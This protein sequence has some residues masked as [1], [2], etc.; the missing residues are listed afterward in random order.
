MIERCTV[1]PRA[2]APLA[3]CAVIAVHSSPALAQQN[4]V[5]VEEFENDG[6]IW[7]VRDDQEEKL[8]IQSG[9]CHLEYKK[10][11]GGTLFLAKKKVA[12]NQSADFQI[13]TTMTC[14][15][16]SA[17]H[18]L[19][20]G[21]KDGRHYYCAL[22]S[23]QGK[24]VYARC[25]GGKL[26]VIWRR[27]MA[28][29]LY[30][31]SPSNTLTVKKIGGDVVFSLNGSFVA[32]APFQAFF[33]DHVGFMLTG[34]LNVQVEN[35]AIVTASGTQLPSGWFARSEGSFASRISRHDPKDQTKLKCAVGRSGL[36]KLA[37]PV[38]GSNVVASVTVKGGPCVWD[39]S[40]GVYIR[41]DDGAMLRLERTRVDN[42]I[43]ARLSSSAGGKVHGS[44]HIVLPQED[45]LLRLSRNGDAFKGE[46]LCQ[47][48]STEVASLNWPGLTAKQE[49]G[50]ILDYTKPN[51]KFPFAAYNYELVAPRVEPGM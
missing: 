19:V 30:H 47:G 23:S 28:A 4:A 14:S 6:N 49:A 21:F 34:K 40:C 27:D 8:A 45:V 48:K 35:L 33:G 38:A 26:N 12:I 10:A 46:A 18:G 20:W 42:A 16:G 9:K 44:K 11:R 51:P 7:G 36:L 25:F 22:V 41:T 5:F 2:I 15:A 1:L 37:R 17:L 32:Q 31:P 24:F 29:G 39:S 50:V 43:V 3:V 13:E